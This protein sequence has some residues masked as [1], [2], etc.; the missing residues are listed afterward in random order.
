GTL[1]LPDVTP[2]PVLKLGA[3]YATIDTGGFFVSMSSN[4]LITSTDPGSV[5]YT[6]KCLVST[7][8][9]TGVALQSAGYNADCLFISSDTKIVALNNII[10]KDSLAASNRALSL[11]YST[12]PGTFTF[13]GYNF[14]TAVLTNVNTPNL[15]SGLVVMQNATGAKAGPLYENDP[16][17]RVF[18]QPGDS[19]SVVKP[20]GGEV[21]T[22]GSTQTIKWTTTGSIPKLKLEYSMDDFIITNFVANVSTGPNFGTF[23]WTIPNNPSATIK[24]RVS[25]VNYPTINTISNAFTIQPPVAAPSGFT[26][27]TV[28][29]SSIQWRFTDNAS[30]ETGLYISSG[31][32]ISMRLS[33]N[34]GP[35]SGT[36][37][38]TSWWEINLSTNTQY[39]R[40][41]E[42]VNAS[43]N[44]WSA[45]KYAYTAANPPTSSTVISV[46]SASV[47]V[48]WSANNNPSG[49]Y[50]GVAY[51]TDSGFGVVSYTSTT[52]AMNIDVKGL[53]AEITYYLKAKAYN[54]DGITTAYDI[55]VSTKTLPAGAP[56]APTGLT[57]TEV[58]NLSIKWVWSDVANEQGYYLQTSTGGFVAS[59]AADT[60]NY[61]ETG[62]MPNTQYSR[63]VEAYNVTGSSKSVVVSKYT[64]ASIPTN[65]LCSTKNFNWIKLEWSANGNSAGTIYELYQ[66]TASDFSVYSSS[67]SQ[68]LNLLISGLSQLTTYYYQIKSVNAENIKTGPVELTV[69]TPN[70]KTTGPVSG[71]VTQAD[72]T[73]A[74]P[75]LVQLYNNDGTIKIAETF[76][77]SDDGTYLFE[78]LDDGI[79]HVVCS[80]LVNEIESVVY[81]TDIPEN[82]KDVLF[83]LKIKYDLAQVIGK[84]ALVSRAN[85]AGKF[86]PAKQPYVELLQRSRVIA[87]I[88]S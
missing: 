37:G 43:S 45:A 88:N 75:V 73:V 72:G 14:D 50:Y 66:S 32:N 68:S 58:T 67:I 84:I 25:A 15:T 82:S 38:A 63:Y 70:S 22:V 62:L 30:D 12:I 57:A 74:F 5:F 23:N 49:T 86:A 65:F 3:N 77:K 36:G 18:W 76:N 29:V 52:I 9:V 69:Q 46:T 11:G 59:V 28:Y 83:T 7:V 78:N 41:A 51:S 1:L 35:L 16:N 4:N 20:A 87:M 33:E 48:K 21:F 39:T 6:F 61:K 13:T 42:A 2:S 10:Y 71:K 85:F 8:N 79:Y 34:L 47:S 40:Y 19:I 17:D 44:S 80:W 81:K 55:T 56:T 60:V 24:V 31:T 54:G 64:L 26:A 53:S 27:S